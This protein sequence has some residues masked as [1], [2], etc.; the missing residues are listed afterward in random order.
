MKKKTTLLLAMGMAIALGANACGKSQDNGST[1]AVAENKAE[2][3]QAE[4]EDRETM[5]Q[6]SLL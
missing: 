2:A 5:F 3:V 4:A 1:E 6:V